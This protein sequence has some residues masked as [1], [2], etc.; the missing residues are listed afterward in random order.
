MYYNNKG[1]VACRE[2][3]PVS[4]VFITLIASRATDS[5]LGSA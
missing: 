1:M 2:Y 4:I 3:V 5:D